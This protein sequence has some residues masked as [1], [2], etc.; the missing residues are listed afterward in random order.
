MYYHLISVCLMISYKTWTIFFMIS[1]P[2]RVRAICWCI[3]SIYCYNNNILQFI[4]T[5]Y[6]I[7]QQITRNNKKLQVSS[8]WNISGNG[9][10]MEEVWKIINAAVT[11]Y[12][13]DF[14]MWLI[15]PIFNIMT[16]NGQKVMLQLMVS[17]IPSMNG[18]IGGAV[19]TSHHMI[20]LK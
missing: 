16:N 19:M 7:L 10:I 2:D 8:T 13:H 6:N 11:F 14:R 20:C 18:G 5:Y 9:R 15:W 4:T 3:S 17:K 12:D 1:A